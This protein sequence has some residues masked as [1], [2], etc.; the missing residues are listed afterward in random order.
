[1]LWHNLSLPNHYRTDMNSDCLFILNVW[2]SLA[3]D[4]HHMGLSRKSRRHIDLSRENDVTD[5]AIFKPLSNA[6]SKPI[7]LL[8]WSRS[9]AASQIRTFGHHNSHGRSRSQDWSHYHSRGRYT[10]GSATYF[11]G[12]SFNINATMLVR[13][14]WFKAERRKAFRRTGQHVLRPLLSAKP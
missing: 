2:L 11:E 4:M 8:Y 12:I 14:Y 5:Q 1:M 7:C 10:Q 3:Q 6:S 9:V 13:A